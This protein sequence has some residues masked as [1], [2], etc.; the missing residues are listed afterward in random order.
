MFVLVVGLVQPAL[1]THPTYQPFP[2]VC[3]PF[4]PSN[5]EMV[6]YDGNRTIWGRKLFCNGNALFSALPGQNTLHLD[7]VPHPDHLV[8]NPG[9]TGSF[10]GS[11]V[12]VD[13]G[14]ASHET[15]TVP[16]SEGS[17]WH[18]T[19]DVGEPDYVTTPYG[20]RNEEG[21]YQLGIVENGHMSSGDLEVS[22]TNRPQ[23]LTKGH[24][25]GFGANDKETHDFGGA[26]WFNW[27]L[28]ENGHHRD[29]GRGDFNFDLQCLAPPTCPT[30]G[31]LGADGFGVYVC[32]DFH[33]VNSDSQGAVAIG[34]D[35]FFRNY[36]IASL[37]DNG[38]GVGLTV[39]GNLDG[40]NSQVFFGLAEAGTCD[41]VGGGQTDHDYSFNVIDSPLTCH[42][43]DAGPDCTN[44]C[45]VADYLSGLNAQHCTITVQPW[46]HV[47]IAVSGDAAVCD[48]NLDTVKSH[49]SPWVWNHWISGITLSGNYPS[50]VIINV[51]GGADIW[52]KNGQFML[53]GVDASAVVWN[54]GC[55]NAQCDD[56]EDQHGVPTNP[57]HISNVGVKGALLAPDC[58]VDFNNAHIDG[59]YI[60]D[61]HKG[62]GEFHDFLF[63]GDICPPGPCPFTTTLDADSLPAGTVL[64]SQIPGVTVSATN[65]NASHPNL[66][67]V[68]D[69]S[70]PTGGDPDLGTPNQD[71]GGPGVGNG[72]SMGAAGENAVALGNL[73]II[74]E[75]DTD[76]NN[77]GL[78]DNPDDEAAGGTL[79][80]D[81]DTPRYINSL[82]LVDIENSGSRVRA[83]AVGGTLL[84][85]ITI[86]ALG[87]NSV[88]TVTLDQPAVSRLEIELAD[89]GAVGAIDICAP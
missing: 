75:N 24:Q 25:I 36:G 50:T 42:V 40:K 22:F 33:G 38:N 35:A 62:T 80:F 45:E 66:A 10:T 39:G 5:Y 9:S 23:N 51:T 4:Q 43:N 82:D 56:H 17:I 46:G 30:D 76:A 54:F 79:V 29:S 72:G 87:D 18:V 44:R 31:G 69:S 81:F 15:P 8:S 6:D 53:Q 57:L 74:A 37:A 83:F 19:Y 86:P 84:A 85:D 11:F 70:A 55:N 21:E 52:G 73:I 58:N 78:V 3:D 68:F 63:T 67:I 48:L 13:D 88:Q 32:E 77:D 60:V 65:D 49:F 2:G 1:A 14:C 89:S 28:F 64:G 12:L 27:Q 41:Q 34:G 16:V 71:F 7:Y 59:Q 20:T 26:F 47:D 61:G